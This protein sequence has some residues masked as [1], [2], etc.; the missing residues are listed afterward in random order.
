MTEV[1]YFAKF[2]ATKAIDLQ[3]LSLINMLLKKREK[4]KKE[5]QEK[6]EKK[7]KIRFHHSVSLHILLLLFSQ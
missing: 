1:D 7:K 3:T 2:T 5:R 6:K 4:N